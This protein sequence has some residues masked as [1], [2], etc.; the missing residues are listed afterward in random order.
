LRKPVS[1]FTDQHVIIDVFE[2][3]TVARVNEILNE[4]DKYSFSMMQ[5]D[6]NTLEKTYLLH[7]QDGILHKRTS[8]FRHYLRIT[9]NR[10]RKALTRVLLSSHSFVSE[11]LGWVD[12][13]RPVI[14][15]QDRLCRLC[16]SAIE[17]P[18]HALLQYNNLR[19]KLIR[20][21][22]WDRVRQVHPELEAECE[23]LPLV[24]SFQRLLEEPAVPSLLG[25]L[26]YGIMEWFENTPIRVSCA[27]ALT[28]I[29]IH[30]PT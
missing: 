8:C 11:R 10:H 1:D 4:V 22:F 3:L 30:C 26:C 6:L 12:H 21:K 2:D 23:C 18:E 16:G 17:T 24:H 27:W 19:A 5:K 20:H 7:D 9:D 15:Y 13:A 29:S 25:K 28:L 14:P